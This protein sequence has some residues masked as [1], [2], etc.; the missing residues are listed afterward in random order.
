MF[1]GA[2]MPVKMLR[3]REMATNHSAPWNGGRGELRQEINYSGRR[4]VQFLYRAVPPAGLG[5]PEVVRTEVLLCLIGLLAFQ[6]LI[7]PDYHM[8]SSLITSPTTSTLTAP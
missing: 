8:N 3:H 6:R 5:M 2:A 4:Q 7:S 1:V